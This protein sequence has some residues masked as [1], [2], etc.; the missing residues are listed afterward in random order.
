VT[1]GDFNGDGHLDLATVNSF[2]TVAILLGQGDGAFLPAQD[3]EVGLGP[4]AITVGD[5]NG[6]GHL[7]L[8]T[9]NFAASTVS[10]LLGQGDGTFLPA[11]DVGVGVFPVAVTVGDFSGD[12][13]LDLA[14]ANGF[15][16]SI[17]LGQGDGTF[18]AAQDFEVGAEPRSVTVGDF[19]GDGHLDLATANGEANTVSI[20]L[21]QGDGTFLPPQDFGAGEFPRA[22][23][24]GDFNGDGHLDL[25][26]GNALSVFAS[27][28]SILL[29]QGDGTFLPPQNFEVGGVP[30]A[31]TGGDFNGDGHLDLATA[32]G[33][34]NTV[35]ILLGQGD[36]TFL[37]DQDFGVGAIPVAVTG[38]DFNG[39]GRLDLATS[40]F[41]GTVS[42]LINT[43][44]GGVVN[45]L[46]T[47][48]PLRDTFFF[49]E[50]TT[51]CPADFVGTFRFAARLTNVS[52]RTLAEL[53]VTVATLT[54][55][56][57][58]QNADGAPGGVGA[59]L[60]VPRQEG[61]GDGVLGPTEVVDVLFVVCVTEPKCSVS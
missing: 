44:P 29:G 4:Q 41:F 37:A 8:A 45:D 47:F 54:N 60:T 50:D 58:L 32:N 30:G 1:V 17:L 27:T 51:E 49:T 5:F 59:R 53:V 57:L 12:S 25:A 7:D 2:A 24:V 23:T 14:T 42:I 56:N 15:T 43:T 10:I 9:A 20:L 34:A 6:D 16:V 13:H 38:G 55:G 3:F 35:S 33:G 19:N 11:Q 52:E 21:G 26:T 39:D 28:V 36:G 18:L 31:V 48:A 40:N 22:L 61:F 46:V